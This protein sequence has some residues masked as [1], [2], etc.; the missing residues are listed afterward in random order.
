MIEVVLVVRWSVLVITALVV[1]VGVAPEFPVLGVVVN[2]MLLVAV[3]AGVVGGPERGAV[4]GFFCGL[5][6]DLLRGSGALGLSALAY[7]LVG[8]AIGATMTQVLQVRRWS[9]MAI[10]AAGSATGTV[11]FAVEGQLFGE[12]TLTNPRLW[13]IVTVG[14]L[15]NGA[16][17]PIA[18]RAARWAERRDDEPKVLGAID[19]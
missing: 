18:L 9:S 1:Q 6:L 19:V 16:L 17:S 10:V 5:L 13:T 7:T 3:G 12:R 8:A 2:L 15:L 14:A 4:V 11:M